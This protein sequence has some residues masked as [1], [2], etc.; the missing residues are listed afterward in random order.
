MSQNEGD[1]WF[2]WPHWNTKANAIRDVNRYVCKNC[3]GRLSYS[4]TPDGKSYA[5]HCINKN[6]DGGT[7]VIITVESA[8]QMIARNNEKAN[9]LKACF[10]DAGEVCPVQTDTGKNPDDQDDLFLKDMYGI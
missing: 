8:K 3:F 5:V 6:C 7:H 1:P 9:I 2:K 10:K 4:L